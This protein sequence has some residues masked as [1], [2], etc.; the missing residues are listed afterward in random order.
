MFFKNIID[1]LQQHGRVRWFDDKL[2]GTHFSGQF[3]GFGF[4]MCGRVEN[5][6]DVL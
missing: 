4:G 3:S 2:F 5:K 6:R 1:G